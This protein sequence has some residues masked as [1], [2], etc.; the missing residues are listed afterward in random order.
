[1]SRS[2]EERRKKKDGKVS[3]QRIERQI[4]RGREIYKGTLRTKTSSGSLASHYLLVPF[5]EDTFFFGTWNLFLWYGENRLWKC[6]LQES[7]EERARESELENCCVRV[8]P[9]R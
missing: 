6:R 2:Q 7:E 3:G 8:F 9:K 4:E 5:S 1:M